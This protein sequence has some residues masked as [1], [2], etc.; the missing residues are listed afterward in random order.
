MAEKNPTDTQAGAGEKAHFVGEEDIGERS[1]PAK[2]LG[3]AVA[4]GI[5]AIAA[6][7]LGSR[8][9]VP[10]KIITAPG[11]LP[12][13]TGLT[14]LGMAVGLGFRAL[15]F[16]GQNAFAERFRGAVAHFLSDE[17]NWRTALLFAIVFVYVLV[18][19]NFGFTLRYPIAGLTFHFSSF[20][21]YS[22]LVLTL[23]FKVFWRARLLYCVLVAAGWSIALAS[24]FRSG[25]HILLP[26]AN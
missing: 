24:V 20:E 16:G 21:L 11:L 26:G 1:T 22:I 3:A 25:F 9:P 19:L 5:F 7:V 14:L 4:V 23:I 13:L 10:N 17:E 8:L 15:R 6:M 18:V 2:D 12:V